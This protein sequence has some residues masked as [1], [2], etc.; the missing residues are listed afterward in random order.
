[1][2]AA[3][4]YPLAKPSLEILPTAHLP[5]LQDLVRFP[6][7]ND[8][9]DSDE[10]DSPIIKDPFE[11]GEDKFLVPPDGDPWRMVD[12]Y[13]I[14]QVSRF[15][16]FYQQWTGASYKGLAKN[17]FLMN[18]AGIMIN[19][20]RHAFVMPPKE[21]QPLDFEIILATATVALTF[22]CLYRYIKPAFRT[23]IQEAAG[24]YDGMTLLKTPFIRTIIL[25]SAIWGLDL[26]FKFG[27]Q[28]FI[29][30]P[31]FLQQDMFQRTISLISISTI[32]FLQTHIMAEYLSLA[33]V[34]KPP[35]KTV[36]RRALEKFMESLKT[37]APVGGEA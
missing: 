18:A 34:P 8:D 3:G 29:D 12:N 32:V 35:K 2:H 31:S 16:N 27:Y 10:T 21:P 17:L 1:M 33:I 20:I 30:E 15:A 26:P 14:K 5:A 36:P 13:V 23:P 24:V 7:F 37:P 9:N 11:P 6:V 22:Y 28:I 19:P 4:L 25:S